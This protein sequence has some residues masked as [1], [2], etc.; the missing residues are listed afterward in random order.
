M[1]MALLVVVEQAE[2]V[3]LLEFLAA[4]EEVELDSEAEAGDL[5]AQLA[6][7]LDGGL[8]GASGGEEVVDDDDALAGLDGVEM[9]LE[10][11]GAEFE[12]AG[13]LGGGCGELFGF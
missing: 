6:D 4:F 11:V 9:D 10:G 2:D 12:G 7:E 1:Q 5:S 3:V 13:D 8:H